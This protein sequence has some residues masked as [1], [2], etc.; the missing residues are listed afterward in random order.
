MSPWMQNS[1]Y[2]MIWFWN[3]RGRHIDLEGFWN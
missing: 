2:N 3:N 1:S